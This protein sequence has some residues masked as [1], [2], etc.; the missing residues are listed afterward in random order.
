M[1]VHVGGGPLGASALPNL[2]LGSL[3]GLPSSATE[4]SGAGKAAQPLG[5][6][7]SPSSAGP[8]L[9]C[10]ICGAP[11]LKGIITTS[12]THKENIRVLCADHFC[13]AFDKN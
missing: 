9:E 2:A 5:G 13:F 11:R 10:G 3:T 12:S 1:V 6:S 7:V 8:E 4:C